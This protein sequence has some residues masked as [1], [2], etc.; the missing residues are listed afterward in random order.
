MDLWTPGSPSSTGCALSKTAAGSKEQTGWV[1]CWGLG[2]G[3]RGDAWVGS[4]EG[5]DGKQS[6]G[7]DTGLG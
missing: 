6:W 7:V 1:A 5:G 4:W 3:G 2:A